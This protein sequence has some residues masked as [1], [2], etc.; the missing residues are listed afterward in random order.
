MASR[1]RDALGVDLPLRSSVRDADRGRAGRRDRAPAARAAPRSCRPITSFRQDRSSPPP[2]SFAQERYWAGRHLEARS[3]ASTIPMLMHLA[4]P[5]DRACLRQAI[6]AV[7]DRHELLRTSFRDSPEGPVQ[8][9]HP[10][11][12]VA[13]PEVDL[14]RLG[15]AERM[16]EVRR[17]SILDGRSHF[18][19]ERPPLFRSTLFR[20]A[21]EE[22]I[23]LFTIH[24]VASDWWSNSV[25]L[26]EV[27]V[28]YLAFRA[29]QPSPLPPLAGAVS[30]LRPL[31]AAPLL[32]AGAGE[33]GDLLARA[34][35][36]CRAPRSR[37]RPAA[38][39]PADIHRREPR[40]CWCRKSSRGSSMHC[41]RSKA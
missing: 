35:E 40:R 29:G 28:L 20:C 7:V 36:R 21:A 25:L 11:V 34:S 38:S 9:I 5:L 19:Y 27:S 15:A 26:R 16:A 22:H 31:A 4:G 23:L 3:V 17:F 37:R 39:A 10:A 32:R 6:A 30:G 13:L 1:V 12:P 2:L 41:P 14:E 18:D 24:H 8:V 33:P